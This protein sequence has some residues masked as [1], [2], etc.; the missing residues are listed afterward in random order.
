MRLI[1][2]MWARVLLLIW[3]NVSFLLRLC[4][5]GERKR[6]WKP[7]WSMTRRV[8]CSRVYHCRAILLSLCFWIAVGHPRATIRRKN[9]LL[10]EG[11]VSAFLLCQGMPWGEAI[12]FI[13]V[14]EVGE[15]S[16]IPICSQ[17]FFYVILSNFNDRYVIPNLRIRNP[18]EYDLFGCKAWKECF[19][20]NLTIKSR[21]GVLRGH[22]RSL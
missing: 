19:P 13:L 8:V 1:E 6:W 2:L 14:K 7:R 4:F 17:V 5:L 22:N 11:R 10:A 16:I 20:D 18:R 21:A 9:L 3:Y 15:T 12:V